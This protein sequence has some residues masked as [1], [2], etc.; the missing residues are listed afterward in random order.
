MSSSEHYD[1]ATGKTEKLT[2]LKI[3]QM[4]AEPKKRME[5]ILVKCGIVRSRANAIDQRQLHRII[6]GLAASRTQCFR[7]LFASSLARSGGTLDCVCRH[8]VLYA[9]KVV[10]FAESPRDAVAVL[11]LLRHL[12]LCAFY[13]FW[14]GAVQQL[15]ESCS[16]AGI[17]LGERTGALLTEDEVKEHGACLPVSV[18]ALNVAGAP[19]FNLADGAAERKSLPFSLD[20]ERPPHP[21]TQAK[22]CLLLH[23]RLHGMAHKYCHGRDPDHVQQLRSLNT[24]SAEH[25]NAQRKRHDNVLRNESPQ[26]NIFLHLVIAHRR[27]RAINLK[28]LGVLEEE[29]AEKRRRFPSEEWR[30]EVH[31]EFGR[32]Q[33]VRKAR[34][35]ES[36]TTPTTTTRT[37]G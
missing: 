24:E 21:Y 15:V 25:F 26:R 11:L 4:L 20:I 34:A 6:V 8:L 1:A 13:D 2:D 36:G 19:S 27:N 12:P 10:P 22:V 7:K 30:I 33:I 29:L 17:E 3:Q 37:L 32:V 5:D 16:A 35:S 14:C 18:P 9:S 31:P 28:I 23:D